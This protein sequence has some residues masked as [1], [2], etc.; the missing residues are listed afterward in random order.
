M[1]HA[2]LFTKWKV[3]D[4]NALGFFKAVQ[5]LCKL[6]IEVSIREF[7]C[8]RTIADLAMR[9]EW[10]F[11]RYMVTASNSYSRCCELEEPSLIHPGDFTDGMTAN[12]E[13]NL[14]RQVVPVNS[15][16]RMTNNLDISM[17][18]PSL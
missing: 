12:G 18:C 13:R 3:G 1:F 9:D 16:I 7:S 15:S 8:D 14:A 10:V 4:T 5:T 17:K 11:K 2:K 6:I